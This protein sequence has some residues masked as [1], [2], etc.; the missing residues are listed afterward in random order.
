MLDDLNLDVSIYGN[1]VV[2]ATHFRKFDES[3]NEYIKVDIPEDEEAFKTLE[4][5][6]SP[7]YEIHKDENDPELCLIQ[8]YLP[9]NNDKPANPLIFIDFYNQLKKLPRKFRMFEVVTSSWMHLDEEHT[10]RLD[11]PVVAVLVDE[12]EKR[13]CLVETASN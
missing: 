8:K 1:F 11:I 10:G 4:K 7:I 2:V 9:E 3:M 13:I 5:I 6:D 12:E